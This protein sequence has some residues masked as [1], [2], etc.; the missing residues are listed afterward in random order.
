VETVAL[1]DL[2]AS[3]VDKRVTSVENVQPE[4]VVVEATVA[5][6]VDLDASNVDRKV[7]S[8]ES[9]PQ[10]VVIEEVVEGEAGEA[11]EEDVVGSEL[12]Q[13]K[14]EALIAQPQLRIRKSPSIRCLR[15][16]TREIQL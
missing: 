1:V 12:T 3:N 10:V 7:I 6:V 9:V 4:A 2:G 16:T 14:A 11:V 13:E 8:A 15:Y 5:L